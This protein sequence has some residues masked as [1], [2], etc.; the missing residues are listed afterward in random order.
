MK[1]FR[2][3]AILLILL[4][5]LE[6][7]VQAGFLKNGARPGQDRLQ[8]VKPPRSGTK[9]R[10]RTPAERQEAAKPKKNTGKKTGKKRRQDYAWFWKLHS[11]SA[12]R[13]SPSRWSKVIKTMSD[14]RARGLGVTS[15]KTIG[16]IEIAYRRQLRIA[17]TRHGI[18]DALL[19]AVISVESRGKS[20]AVSPKGAQ[21]LM[22]LIPATAKRFGVTNAFDTGQN[23]N[24]GAAYLSWLLKE[25]R[26][27]P[28]L[29]L[30]GYNAGEGAVRKHRGVP[31]YSETRDYVVKVMDAVAL[32][33]S[34]CKAP[35]ASP[36][37]L[38]EWR[39]ELG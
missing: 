34:R 4:G 39:D 35:L 7:P 20:G 12:L 14:R 3:C 19:A 10:I 26:G 28:L 9:N 16:A 8:T 32:I 22:Q 27:D 23:I 25:F 15:R 29:A 33:Q 38:C 11:V 5:F 24:G 30:A 1:G 37:S 2:L 13:G 17:A 21:G 6:S 31:P 36:R 18:S